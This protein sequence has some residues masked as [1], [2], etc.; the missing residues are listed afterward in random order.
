MAT[1]KT[2]SFEIF[3]TITANAAGNTATI[4][5]NTFVQVA[6]LEAFGIQAIEVGI[7]ATEATPLTSSFIVQIA[8]DDLGTGFIN[9]AEYDSLYLKI[10]DMNTGAFEESLSLGDV[11][12][13]RYVPGGILDVRADRLTSANDVDLYV[14]VTGVISKLS[15]ADYMSLALTRAGN[16]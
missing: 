8:L 14:R 12:E 9:H 5:L 2:R 16:L 10:S 1:K 7:N 3:E 6:D 11:S 15:A 13:I 4:D